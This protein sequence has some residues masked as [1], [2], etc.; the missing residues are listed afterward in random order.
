MYSY[1]VVAIRQ[2][3]AFGDKKDRWLFHRG[4]GVS[5]VNL[6]VFSC[7]LFDKSKV[8]N[9]YRYKSYHYTLEML[10]VNFPNF[11]LVRDIA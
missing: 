11:N 1:S 5:T 10:Y 2:F 7:V 8:I 4:A 9:I 3:G 6:S